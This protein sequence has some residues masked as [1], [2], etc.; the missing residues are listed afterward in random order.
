MKKFIKTLFLI[1]V[2]TLVADR[3]IGYIFQHFYQ[4]TTTTD[5]HKLSTVLYRTKAPILFMGSSR[6]HHHYIPTIISDTLQQEVYNAGLWGMRNIYFQYGLLSNLL[7]R[8]KPQ[9]ILLE[10]HPIDYLQTP[11]SDV[12]RVGNLAPF[13][14]YS[15]GCDEVL[16]E[17]GLYYKCQL[18]VLYRYNSELVNV[19]LG[20]L[21]DRSLKKQGYKPLEG[22]LDTLHQQITPEIFDFAPDNRKMY[23]L[24]SFI[25]RC[26][27]ENINLIFLYSPMYA[28][29][30]QTNLF[31]IPD[32]IARI[33]NLPFINNYYMEGITGYPE[34]YADY[35]HLNDEGAHKYSSA[36]ASMLKKCIISK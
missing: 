17:A 2:L 20:N 15:S 12:E 19:L 7:E 16:N 22:R 21:S 31:D 27:A 29:Q 34:Y 1:I 5:E 18:S 32:S 33:N 24:Q 26:R 6:C 35:G 28:T 30:K 8:Y 3:G 36:I 10:I 14:N 11:F 9:T 4:S 25:D 23:Y 13:I